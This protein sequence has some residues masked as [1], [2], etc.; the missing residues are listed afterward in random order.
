[1]GGVLV[2]IGGKRSAYRVLVGRSEGKRSLGSSKRRL[3]DNI[4]MDHLQV[5]WGMDWIDLLRIGT[6]GRR[7]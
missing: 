5:T 2:G 7:L 3:D 4:K 1:M 6:G